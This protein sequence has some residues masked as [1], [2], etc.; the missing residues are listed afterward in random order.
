MLLLHVTHAQQTCLIHVSFYTYQQKQQIS[1]HTC[2]CFT[3]LVTN[4]GSYS[5]LASAEAVRR[6]LPPI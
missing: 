1:Q 6:I 2:G 5:I 3:I 4:F